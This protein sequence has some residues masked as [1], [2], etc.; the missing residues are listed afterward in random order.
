MATSRLIVKNLPN[1]ATEP[2]VKEFFSGHGIVTDVQLKFT[3]DGRFRHF[4]FV[5]FKTE[6]EAENAQKYFHNTYFGASKIQV[7][8]CANLGDSS[9]P[10]AWSKYAAENIHPKAT[11]SKKEDDSVDG[12][13][14]RKKKKEEEL[15]E[16]CKEDPSL[17][18]FLEAHMQKST[19]GNDAII[20]TLESQI[21]GKKK[22]KEK[23]KGGAEVEVQE[24][25]ISEVKTEDEKS[26]GKKA[27]KKKKVVPDKEYFTVK[28]RN[29]PKKARKKDLKT[30]F[31]PLSLKSIRLPP[32]F[33]GFAYVG[34]SSEDD[35]TKAIR[36]NK[37]FI[38]GN[39]ISVI[40]YESNKPAQLQA[41][42]KR[43]RW[44]QQQEDLERETETV[45]ESGRI[46]L[47]NLSYDTNEDEIKALFE[48][49][50]PVTEV[51]LPIDRITRQ[52]K[53]FGFI[54]FLLPEHAAK[55]FSELDGTVLHGR[56]LHLLPAKSKDELTED[57]I[58]AGSSFKRS[59]ELKQKKT[60]GSS[61]NWNSLFLGQ[62]AVAE[63]I[64]DKYD[65]RKEELLLDN[66]DEKSRNIASV[67]V[68]M[69][70]AETEIVTETKKFLETHGVCLDAFESKDGK[71]TRSTTCMLVK[72]LPPKTS[73]RELDEIFS[74]HGIIARIVLPPSGVT[75][76]V[77]YL[78]PAEA[79]A[80]FKKLAYSKFK[81]IPL[82][83]EWAPVNVFGTSAVKSAEQT[84]KAKEESNKEESIKHDSVSA[85]EKKQDLMKPEDLI[86]PEP[87]T[88]LFVKNLNFSTTEAVLKK[89]FQET[90]SVYA[91]TIATKK[92]P[93]DPRQLLSMGYGFVQFYRAHDALGALKD[94][95]KSMLENHFLELK[96]SNRT[97]HAN[98]V[99][100]N[101]NAKGNDKQGG[102]KILV[103]NVPF[104]AS[105]EEIVQ[106]FKTFGELK[107]IRLPMKLDGSGEH[108]G[109]C[110]IDYHT[111]LEA[112]RAFDTI[113]KSTHLY[114]RR[115]ALEW[116]AEDDTVD[117]LRM[118]TAKKFDLQTKGAQ[119]SQR[120]KAK[121][122]MRQFEQETQKSKKS[123]DDSE[124]E[125]M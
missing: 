19:W 30:F 94:Q 57:D 62:N 25:K 47:R 28:L 123:Q 107:A 97:L 46:F 52:L 65:V 18:E 64:A 9:K 76:I 121:Q 38:L 6:A 125:D 102:S 87:D 90:G 10:R 96:R 117:D 114:G 29:L 91:V 69:A 79:R 34:F 66:N 59:K 36:K 2:K 3:A 42:S 51:H 61:H 92:D 8:P 56:M 14:K 49:F 60:A 84:S 100:D 124:D 16:K 35:R 12:E 54:S 68:R 22:D 24:E 27:E 85:S 78:E 120:P 15:L 89:H 119:D 7:E 37:G 72:N 108:R 109:F 67:G 70:L 110:F 112:K 55:S 73:A 53:G 41:E 88:T 81:N 122:M 75:A 104:Q 21:K 82:Y 31:S 86:V 98:P 74:K 5:G 39:Q 58:Q 115:L 33:R 118:K 26:E 101:D 106:L 23:H 44:E 32:N 99:K 77:E 50:G 1:S 93:K 105:K 83:L 45:G 17:V 80:G 11:K 103:R 116:A 13:P 4:G 113:S 111:K 71:V 63:I 95:Q 20:Q 40:K 43:N 48:K